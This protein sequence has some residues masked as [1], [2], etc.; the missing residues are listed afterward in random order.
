MDFEYS[1]RTRELTT[2][3]DAFMHEHVYPNEK[4]HAAEVAE[5]DRWQPIRLVDELI[6]LGVEQIILV[7]GAPEAAGPH[8]LAAAR[9]D[10]RGRLGEYV[11]ST[12]AA[13]D[14]FPA[15]SCCVAA[16]ID[17][18]GRFVVYAPHGLDDLFELTVRPNS[19]IAP[20]RVYEAKTARWKERWPQL[21][22]IAWPS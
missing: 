18:A 4:R 22:V 19:A 6:D 16:R 11:Q 9:L 3:L 14:S 21:H 2:R 12:E 17:T 5:G 13:I 8:T 10:G 7:S 20:R 15:A 1:A